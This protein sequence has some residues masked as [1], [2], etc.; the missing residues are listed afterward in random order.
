MMKSR[1]QWHVHYQ[2]L[3]REAL[4]IIFGVK[5]FNQYLYGCSF[6]L[7]T[8]HHPL[9]KLFG[10]AD[11]ARPVAAA[12]MQRWALILSAYSYKI[13]YIAGSTN[14]CADCLSCLPV[15]GT[16]RHPAEKGNE[17]HA[18]NCYTLPVTARDIFSYTAKDPTLSKVFTCVQHGTW[19]F[20]LPEELVPYHGRK[21]N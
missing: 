6:I 5:R 11:G 10:H 15:P 12:R 7:A 16:K 21:T 18:T 14:S 1:S 13:E 20:P 8:D 19:R 17:I 4:G 2:L 9:C 3:E